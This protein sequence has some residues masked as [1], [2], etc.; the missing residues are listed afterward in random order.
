MTEA[1]TKADIN[2]IYDRLE[3]MAQDLAS[4][5]TRLDLTPPPPKQP[6]TFLET[7]LDDHKK[8]ANTWKTSVIRTV[9]DVVKMAIVA[10]VTYFFVKK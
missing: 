5:K 9:V 7:H 2:R 10:V 8:T 1:A 6:C 4:I 3:P